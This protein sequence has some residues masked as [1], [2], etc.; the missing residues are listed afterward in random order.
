M[1]KSEKVFIQL[2]EEVIEL[3][4]ADK[5]TF[6]AQR[7]TNNSQLET[8]QTEVEAQKELKKSAYAKLGLTEEEINA[9]L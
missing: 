4:G 8:R 7:K 3:T 5:E 9:I 2:D 6:I 1:T